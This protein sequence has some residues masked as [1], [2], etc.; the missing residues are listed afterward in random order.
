MK[1]NLTYALLAAM[2]I[3]A[4]APSNA[5]VLKKTAMTFA[6]ADSLKAA[7]SADTVISGWFDVSPYEFLAAEVFIDRVYGGAGGAGAI[8]FQGRVGTRTPENIFF[9]NF[10]DSLATINTLAVSGAADLQYYFGLSVLPYNQHSQSSATY[11]KFPRVFIP[12][13]GF[14]YDQVRFYLLDTN[15]TLS[16]HC[17]GTWLTR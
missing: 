17:H 1:K 14:P 3:F 10:S 9:V 4:V 2:L 6:T 12:G 8:Y 16:G 13:M 11:T 7:T 15:W 5:E